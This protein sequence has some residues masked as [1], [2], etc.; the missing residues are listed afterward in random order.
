MHPRI[1]I[2]PDPIFRRHGPHPVGKIVK[3]FTGR[4]GK[5]NIFHN[6]QGLEQREM[7][8]HHADAKVARMLR[9][10]NHHWRALPLK[11]P[12]IRLQQAVYHL[13]KG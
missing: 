4:H 1:R 5:R 10:A 2:N 6:S 13:H 7:L 3:G 8:E 9:V 12:R 11:L